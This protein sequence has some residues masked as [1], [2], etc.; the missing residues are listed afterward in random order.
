M[1]DTEKQTKDQEW[2]LGKQPDFDGAW[3]MMLEDERMSS[4]RSKLSIHE[5]RMLF[6]VAVEGLW[7]PPQAKD[8]SGP[9]N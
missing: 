6:Y 3:K 7:G 8:N 9:D 5:V 4:I 2:P 1:T